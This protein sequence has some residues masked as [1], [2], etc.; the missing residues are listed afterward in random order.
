MLKRLRILLI[1]VARVQS[2]GVGAVAEEHFNRDRTAIGGTQQA[3]DDLHLAAFAVSVVAECG[4]RTALSFDIGG[5]DIVENQR[6]AAQVAIAG[7]SALAVTSLEAGEMMRAM[8][9]ASA[10][11]R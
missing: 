4:K 8:M 5:G 2:T 1:C 3:I 7:E 9:A 10:R 6:A 11:S